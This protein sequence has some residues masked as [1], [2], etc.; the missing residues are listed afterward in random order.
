MRRLGAVLMAAGLAVAPSGAVAGP[1]DTKKTDRWT[2]IE[3]SS[4]HRLGV[5]VHTLTPE[6][7][8]HFGAAKDRGVLV[9]RVEPGSTAAVAGIQVGDVIV[10]VRGEVV[11][12]ASD[13]R[14]ALAKAKQGD[15]ITVHVVRNRAAMTLQAKLA[16]PSAMLDLPRWWRSLFTR[17]DTT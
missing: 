13:V 5:L 15:A 2:Q 1:S 6:L 17:P 14:D 10:D 4:K 12:D 16:E 8:E 3:A 11:D 9:A 7:R